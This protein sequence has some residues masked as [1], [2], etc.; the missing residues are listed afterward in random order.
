MKYRELG[1]TKIM[2]SEIAL[3]GEWLE[4]QTPDAVKAV[5]DRCREA[6]IN[7]IDCFMSEPNV[8]SNIGNAIKEDRE[9]WIIQGHIGSAWRDG[10]YVRTR[11]MDEVKSAFAD[12]LN[13]FHTDY[14]DVGMIHFVDSLETWQYIREN[15]ILDY[16]RELKAAGVTPDLI[17]LS[18]GIENVDDIIE[19]ISQALDAAK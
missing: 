8:R 9:K 4:R 17:R 10:Q 11:D 6:G 19:D 14:M 3:G 13:R 15:G 7:F 16:A 1:N 5:V 18:V 2:V 12:L